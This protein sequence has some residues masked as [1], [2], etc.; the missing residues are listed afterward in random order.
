MSDHADNADKR[1]YGAIAAGLAAARRA[2][3]L[4]PDCRC[5]FCEEAVA[6][7]ILFCN[8]DCRDDFQRL[9]NSRVRA[10]TF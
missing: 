6:P 5:H 10:G 7:G 9:M 3:M 4:Q 2:P 8:S 1:I